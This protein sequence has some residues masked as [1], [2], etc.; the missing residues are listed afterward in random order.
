MKTRILFII[1]LSFLIGVLI[2]NG[3][4]FNKMFNSP[5]AFAIGDLTVD[6]GVPE[7]NP[8]FIVNDI[9]PGQIESRT[10]QVSN[11]A[12]S[13]RPVG[14]RGIE[15][16]DSANLSDVMEITISQGSTDLYGGTTG[17][18]T[19]TQFFTESSG[20]NGIFLSNLGPLINTSYIFKVKFSE[21][22]GNT[23]QGQSIVFDLKIGISVDVPVDCQSIPNLNPNTIFGTQGNDNING[24]LGNDLIVGFEGND[25]INGGLGNDCILGGEGN[26]QLSGGLGN[27][28][29]FGGNGQ[30]NLDG[31]LGNDKLF[32]EADVDKLN[33][34]VGNDQILGGDG[35]DDISG[36]V[37]DDQINGG[38]GDD[39]IDGGVGVD[40]VFGEDGN[41]SING[42]VG[43]DNLNGGLGSDSANGGVGTDTCDAETKIQCEL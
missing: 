25:K 10:V 12:I 23:Y 6:W 42:G 40:T 5:T 39:K 37:D 13:A 27:D 19:L 38:T 17:I 7:G 2:V 33:G 29:L 28:V 32:G 36:G 15:A 18:K 41:D 20:I 1:A 4:D 34:G 11:G 22:A 30:D 9:A 24:T 26:D 31:G 35:N 43:N 21:A 14:V 3:N 16:T 8:I